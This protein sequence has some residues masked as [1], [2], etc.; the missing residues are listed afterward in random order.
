MAKK[1]ILEEDGVAGE[2]AGPTLIRHEPLTVERNDNHIYFYSSVNSDRCLA[3]IQQI[4]YADN[5]LR[6]QRVDRSIPDDHPRIPIWL[7][8]NSGGGG[9]F[10]ALALTDQLKQIQTPIYSIVEGM[11][12]SAATLISMSCTRRFIQPSSYML[13]HQITSLFWGTFE[14]FK[15]EVHLLDMLMNTIVGF[16]AEGSKMKKR[17]IKKLL[18]R[19]SWFNANECVEKGLVDGIMK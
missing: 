10:S 13:I 5:N 1:W 14:E 3:L 12:A 4:R 15:D 6:T 19:D 11:C 17:E 8:I 7:H 16:Y 2:P 18:Q 9:V